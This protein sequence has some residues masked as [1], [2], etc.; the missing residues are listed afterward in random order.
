MEEEN[1]QGKVEGVLK[2][3]LSM[4]Q[5]WQE[6]AASEKTGQEI[7]QMQQKLAAF[8]QTTRPNK[9]DLLTFLKTIPAKDLPLVRLLAREGMRLKKK[10]AAPQQGRAPAAKRLKKQHKSFV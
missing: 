9:N 5:H 10:L 2:A 6:G 4:M 7:L 8:L 1:K 3:A